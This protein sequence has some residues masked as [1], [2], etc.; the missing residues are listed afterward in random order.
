MKKKS[1]KKAF[2]LV[3]LLVVIAII[4]ILFGAWSQLKLNNIW[5][6]N[7]LTIFNN[8]IITQFETIRNN[9]LLGKWINSSIWV[10]DA[11]KITYS[12]TAS[13]I[14]T[15]SYL[16]G[17]WIDYTIDILETEDHYEISDINCLDITQTPIN[18]NITGAELIISWNTFTLTWACTWSSKILEFTTQFRTD[19]EKIQI[20][21]LN[22]LIEV[23]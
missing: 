6:S 9:S 11:W 16:S 2:T 14:I 18:T 8:K 19:T 17:T 13:W 7:K 21:T 1:I 4:A 3:E 15:P 5:D 22:W 20:N 23:Q 10:P 12:T